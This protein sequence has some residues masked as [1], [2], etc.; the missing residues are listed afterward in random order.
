MS[1]T[2]YTQL[3]QLFA[4]VLLLCAVLIVWRRSLSAWERL[5]GGTGHGGAETPSSLYRRLRRDMLTA[6][7]EVFVR[8]RDER[9]LDDEVLR[10]VMAQLDFEEAILER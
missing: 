9:R 8:L 2:T 7:R 1:E 3:L 6:E 4:G 10:E 5:G